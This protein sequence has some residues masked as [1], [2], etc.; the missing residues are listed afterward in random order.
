[1]SVIIP[2][3]NTPELLVRALQSV[4]SQQLDHGW[5]EIMVVDNGSR[6]PLGAIA[7]AWPQ[8]RFLV[9]RTPG[10]G[11][12]RNRG[13]AASAADSLAFVDADVRVCPGWLQA[14]V[15]ALEADGSG[16]IGGDIRIDT[17]GKRRLSGVEAF[18]CVFSFRQ[19]RYIEREHYS[20]TANL[21]M[22]RDVFEAVGPFGG[23]DTAED[24]DF[25][26]RAHALGYRTRYVPAMRALHPARASLE[27]MRRKWRRLSSHGIMAHF[28]AGRSRMAW[29]MKAMAVA[30]SGPAHAPRMLVSRR[31]SG[32]GNRLRGLGF[33]L[34]IRWARALD[35]LIL[36]REAAGVGEPL[37]M[38]WNR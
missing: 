3:L 22:T 5:F 18:E 16:P 25:G 24:A 23:L 37:A 17:G 27:E 14:G 7:A 26:R 29:N 38:N 28:Q 15:D 13:I 9:E 11:P 19:Q 21:M 6:V 33:L 1:V 8:V 34:R 36:A 30:L 35:M 31:V 2:H 32:L 20:V 4:S 10:P 12:A